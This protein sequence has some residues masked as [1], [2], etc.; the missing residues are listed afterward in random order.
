MV[1]KFVQAIL[2]ISVSFFLAIVWTFFSYFS[3]LIFAIG[4]PFEKYGF[5][6]VRK[7]ESSVN[8]ASLLAVGL[9]L[10]IILMI[11]ILYYKLPHYKV[12]A[13]TL[14]IT[15]LIFSILVYVMFSSLLWF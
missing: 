11:S 8:G 9:F 14:I 7:S 15:S 6:L 4:E 10:L 13:M 12:F 1:K 5:E 2:A 3:G